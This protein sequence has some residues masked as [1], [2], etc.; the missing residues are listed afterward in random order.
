MD[1]KPVVSI[2]IPVYNGSNY[3][4]EAIDS[5]LAQ[6]CKDVEV[7]V[8]NDGSDD[9]GKTEKIAKSYGNSIR[10]F[11]KGNGGVSSALNLGIKEM[12]GEWFAWLS[13]DD[14]LSN[15]RIEEDL[16]LINSNSEVKVTFCK[17]SKIDAVGNEIESIKYPLEKVTGPWDVMVLGGVG[18][19]CMTIHKSCFEKS[20][21]FNESNQTTQDVEMSLS[22]SKY[23]PFSFNKN[24][25]T[26]VRIH[27]DSGTEMRKGN[28]HK[29]KEQHEKDSLLLADFMYKAFSFKDFFPSIRKN[30][31]NETSTAWQSLG[32]LYRFLGTNDYANECYRNG[33]QINKKIL[34]VV[35]I[36]YL[37]GAKTLNSALF[38]K[39][40]AFITK[41]K[42]IA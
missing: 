14:I 6:T 13:H 30:D 1:F 23:Y 11:A 3:M 8:V 27:P 37:I 20:G 5:A 26:Y 31:S 7:I 9:G 36:K 41:F 29:L 32:D 2:I 28:K 40:N 16:K 18:L 39:I 17:M 38:S 35:G 42:I 10:Y 25:L 24:T 19:C 4:R 34:S 12:K 15:N 22:L 21:V 33:Y